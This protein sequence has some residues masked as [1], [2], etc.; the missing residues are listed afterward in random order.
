[1]GGGGKK[2]VCPLPCVRSLKGGMGDVST[3]SSDKQGLN[4]LLR[5]KGN[6][7]QQQKYALEA[8]ADQ[9]PGGESEGQ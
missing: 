5:E 3:N 2:K 7:M 6:D 4:N 8:R 9:T 1:M